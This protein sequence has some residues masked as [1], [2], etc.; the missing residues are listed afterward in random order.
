ML[1]AVVSPGPAFYPLLGILPEVVL[2]PGLL[3]PV[4]NVCSIWELE[5]GGLVLPCSVVSAGPGAWVVSLLLHLRA[6]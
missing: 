5:R 6:R 2:K 3:E 1:S 4:R